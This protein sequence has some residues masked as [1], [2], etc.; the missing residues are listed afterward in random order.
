MLKKFIHIQN[1]KGK[2]SSEFFPEY[3]I[4]NTTVLH[5]TDYALLSEKYEKTFH[6]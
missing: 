6:I 3:N 5:K 2:Q 1:M 4:N